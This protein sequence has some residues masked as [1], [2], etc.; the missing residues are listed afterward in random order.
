MGSL[1]TVGVW[2]VGT[3]LT[4]GAG[5]VLFREARLGSHYERAA[6]AAERAERKFL[7]MVED[8]IARAEFWA[9]ADNLIEGGV[10]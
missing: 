7:L 10:R 3:G 9:E 5:F 4:L 8:D 6:Q 1:F 2:F